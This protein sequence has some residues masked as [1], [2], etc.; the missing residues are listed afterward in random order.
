MGFGGKGAN[1][2]VAAAKLGA[3]TAM[4]GK[5]CSCFPIQCLL[6]QRLCYNK[7]PGPLPFLTCSHPCGLIHPQGM[8]ILSLLFNSQL[9][10]DVYGGGFKTELQRLNVNIGKCIILIIRNALST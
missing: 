7:H 10:E 4:V 2:C 8:I 1:Q 9:G 6:S 5:V 3:R